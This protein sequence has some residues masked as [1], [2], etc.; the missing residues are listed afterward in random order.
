MSTAKDSHP[1]T[2]ITPMLAIRNAADAI[3]WY[4]KVFQAEEVTRLKD[5]NG[6]IAHAELRIG[7]SRIMLAEEHPDYNRSPTILNGT[8]VIIHLYVDNVD[9]VVVRAVK[10][11]AR[12]IFAVKDQFY[13][14]RSGRFEDPF[15]HM[16]IISTTIRK[17]PHEE[18]QRIFNEM[19]LRNEGR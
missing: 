4:G 1:I 8:S 9:E 7:N 12:L 5:P 6:T 10:E 16:W 3:V 13:G 19:M 17:V 14:D 11:G 15:G 2:S 18:M